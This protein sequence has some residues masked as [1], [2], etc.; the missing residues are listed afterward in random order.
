MAVYIVMLRQPGNDDPRDDP[1]WEFGSFGCTGCHSR[2]LLAPGSSVLR[3]GDRLAFAQGGDRGTRLVLLTP[4]ISIARHRYGLEASWDRRVRPFRYA[5][6]PVL[7]GN[8][9]KSDIPGVARY[10][11]ACARPTPE[12]KFASKFR[13]RTRPLEP[14]L[15]VELV[16]VFDRFKVH[17]KADAFARTYTQ[18]MPWFSAK[19]DPD[20]GRTYRQLRRDMGAPVCARGR[21][22]RSCRGR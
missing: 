8:E 18:A 3:N 10:V 7:V 22:P 15:A 4:P 11:N 5:A 12:S 19:P 14:K 21:K 1:F 17:A 6:A 2:N 20:R 9:V 13:G 16:T